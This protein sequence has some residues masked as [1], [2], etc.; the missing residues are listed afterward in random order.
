MNLVQVGS[1]LLRCIGI[2]MGGE[3]PQF[4]QADPF[5]NGGYD[6]EFFKAIQVEPLQMQAALV[7]RRFEFVFDQ[8]RPIHS[9]IPVLRADCTMCGGSDSFGL[10]NTRSMR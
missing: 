4:T 3:V 5:C 9:R 8:I 1:I 6:L 10:F 7:Y 2:L